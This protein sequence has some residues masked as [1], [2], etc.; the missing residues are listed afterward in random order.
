MLIY[1]LRRVIALR[2]LDKSHKFLV[3]NGFSTSSAVN[4][5]KY[6][7]TSMR[8]KA[9][10]T[11]CVA[12]NCEPSDLFEWRD[13]K[14]QTLPPDHALNKLRRDAVKNLS[15][16]INTLP[17]ER[18]GEVESFLQNLKDEKSRPE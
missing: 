1:N 16:I 4:M 18:M 13:D 7:P 15:E 14:D 8:I 2:G 11:L 12:L 3:E 5:L 10:S 17:L 9:I 6:Y